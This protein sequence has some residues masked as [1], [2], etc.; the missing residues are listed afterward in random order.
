[1]IET[2]NLSLN[3]ICKC[4]FFVFDMRHLYVKYCSSNPMSRFRRMSLGIPQVF[5]REE[6]SSRAGVSNP[7]WSTNFAKI[8]DFRSV[9]QIPTI[10]Q[11]LIQVWAAIGIYHPASIKNCI[12]Y[13]E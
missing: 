9:Y 12:N 5:H 2:P 4:R 8:T 13:F 10:I 3:F 11:I 6:W 7:S 1:M